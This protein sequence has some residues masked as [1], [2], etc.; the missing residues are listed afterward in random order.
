MSN[1]K[2]FIKT[3]SNTLPFMEGKEKGDIKTLLGQELTIIEFGFLADEENTDYA[4]VVFKEE[5]K[6]FY[7]APSV[8]SEHL[9][10]ITKAGYTVEDVKT[11]KLLLEN[12][13]SKNKRNYTNIIWVI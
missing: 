2:D 10:K 4:V 13:M 1:F 3:L 9:L 12:K 11:T 8:L 5:P 6:K 7:F